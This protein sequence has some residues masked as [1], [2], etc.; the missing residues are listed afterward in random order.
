[1]NLQPRE[2]QAIKRRIKLATQ[3][4]DK[5]I[6]DDH[7]RSL[8][9]YTGKHYDNRKMDTNRVSVNY[10]L[11]A[12]ETKVNS[13]AFHYPEFVI[14][15][16]SPE[17]EGWE[18]VAKAALNYSWKVGGIQEEMR[19]GWQD[20]EIYS[21]GIIYTGWLFTTHDGTYMDSGR[22][23]VE[24]EMP[25]QTPNPG[26]DQNP[27][28]MAEVRDDRFLAKRINPCNFFVCPES[29]DCIYSVDYCGY[30]ELRTLD[31]VKSDSR[32]KNTR[33]LKG[34][35]ENLQ[36][37][38]DEGMARDYLNG[39]N[40][41][42]I[43]ADIKRVKLYHYYER[44]RKLHVVMCEEHDKELLI[45]KWTWE[46]DRYPFRIRFNPGDTDK[47]WK[48]CS[49]LL[50]EH[51]QKELNQARSQLADHR[52]RFVP[53]FQTPTG[54]LS[55]KAKNGLK[56]ADAG[57]VVEHTGSDPAP[58]VPIQMPNVQP[59]VYATETQVNADIQTIL[60]I[61]AYQMG[62]PPSKRTPTA[63][64]EAIQS[65]GSSRSEND[66]QEF[67]SWC[68]EVATDCLDWLKMYSVKT[69]TLPIYNNAGDLQAWHDFTGEQIRGEFD[70]SVYVNST[71]PPNNQERLQS[72]AF[73]LQN[74][75]PLIQIAQPAMMVGI[76]VIPLIRQILD[77]LPEIR[78]TNEIFTQAA[79]PMLDPMAMA[80]ADQGGGDPMAAGGDAAMGGQVPFGPIDERKLPP[81]L[82]ALLSQGLQQ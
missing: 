66:R 15:P 54:I 48:L 67:E 47:F 37:Y 53:K 46:H 73:L 31:E 20:K 5:E 76:N 80:G 62:K 38:F 49:P 50:I 72:I 75:N 34:N 27:V 18:K 23:L 71:T 33:Q 35:V 42:G 14:K 56:S 10:T 24:G 25:D 39:D 61:N 26:Q 32:Y 63:E 3:Y 55:A 81:D 41:S 17:A 30:W 13:V 74:I 2:I 29:G 65:Q 22:P 69:R 8:D 77:S 70:V 40:E 64:V 60:G 12:I 11:N 59:E 44:K 82:I 52:R 28:P 9:Q 4:Y 1:M 68:A 36:P 7:K 43:P 19:R 78:D 58:I 45:E 6:K 21:V 51:Q 57:E 16:A 79:P